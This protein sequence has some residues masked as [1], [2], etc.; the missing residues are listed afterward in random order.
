LQKP[1]AWISERKPVQEPWLFVEIAMLHAE[2][3]PEATELTA[4]Q[5]EPKTGTVHALSCMHDPVAA[6]PFSTGAASS[7]PPSRLMHEVSHAVHESAQ[8]TPQGEHAASCD[9]HIEL[10]Q[11]LH[12]DESGNE[13]MSQPPPSSPVAPLLLP[14]LLPLELPELDPLPELEV[15]P[16]LLE[17]LFVEASSPLPLP[18]ES[19]A[20]ELLEQATT[21][22][23]EPTSTAHAIPLTMLPPP[24]RA[25]QY[26]RTIPGGQRPPI[27]YWLG[28]S[29]VFQRIVRKASRMLGA[30]GAVELIRSGRFV[31]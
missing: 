26:G 6:S 28:I 14:L 7:S 24:G 25:A 18:P 22:A 10:T 15:E 27:G 1:V 31:R 4:M 8:V 19:G 16:P 11:L 23:N 5:P 12:V 30:P 21:A 13:E 17:E 29:W 2:S 9:A 20:L 3:V